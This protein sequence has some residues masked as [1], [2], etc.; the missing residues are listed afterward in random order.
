MPH[1][2]FEDWLTDCHPLYIPLCGFKPAVLTFSLA[3]AG[4]VEAFDT[5]SRKRI[6][7]RPFP[8]VAGTPRAVH[9]TPRDWCVIFCISVHNKS[10][11]AQIPIRISASKGRM[12]Q[13]AFGYIQ[14]TT[15]LNIEVFLKMSMIFQ[16]FPEKNAIYC[17]LPW[18]FSVFFMFCSKK[19]G[20][21]LKSS[22]KF[23]SRISGVP[24]PNCMWRIFSWE[25]KSIPDKQMRNIKNPIYKKP[26]GLQA[27]RFLICGKLF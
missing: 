20:F 9:T 12:Q 24:M 21:P 5:A 2:C 10:P 19:L 25:Q 14:E 6:F 7:H 17:N 15:I 13:A 22:L 27:T 11:P 3:P 16:K 1:W 8:A 23:S 26:Y 18:F 4:S